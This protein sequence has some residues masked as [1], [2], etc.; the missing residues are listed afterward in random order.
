MSNADDI[1]GSM[2]GSSGKRH[3]ITNEQQERFTKTCFR[4]FGKALG[5]HRQWVDHIIERESVIDYWTEMQDELG[6][7]MPWYVMPHRVSQY[8]LM[9]ILLWRSP[10]KNNLLNAFQEVVDLSGEKTAV[11]P[12][13]WSGTTTE[14]GSTLVAVQPTD[15]VISDVSMPYLAAPSCS[16]AGAARI[17]QWRPWLAHVRRFTTL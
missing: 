11:M 3:H 12:F 17:V 1:L 15:P 14:P 7:D 4:D 10:T 16:T 6:F 13:R 2:R 5:L 8:N 9:D